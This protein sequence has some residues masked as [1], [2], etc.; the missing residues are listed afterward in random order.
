MGTH[1]LHSNIDANGKQ[2]K[3]L[4]QRDMP[5][6]YAACQVCQARWDKVLTE[7]GL[8][9]ESLSVSAI[10]NYVDL[11]ESEDLRE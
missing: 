9:C 2:W 1:C 7:E 5:Q 6:I 3:D 11:V 8:F 4:C 10:Y